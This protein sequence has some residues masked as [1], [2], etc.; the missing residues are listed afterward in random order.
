M[1]SLSGIK[2]AG[3]EVERT[4]GGK[5]SS[6]EEQ[7]QRVLNEAQDVEEEEAR[8]PRVAHDPGR[9]ARKELVEHLSIT[10]YT[11]YRLRH[12]S[13]RVYTRRHNN[14]QNCT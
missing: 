8:I 13:C 6:G 14:I 3:A 5:D 2:D 7:W 12:I 4:V 1:K 11:S 10:L 9:P